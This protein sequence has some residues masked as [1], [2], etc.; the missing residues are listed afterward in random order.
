[1]KTPPNHLFPRLLL[2][3]AVLLSFN[4]TYG[5]YTEIR[6]RVI[7]SKAKDSSMYAVAYAN[8]RLKGTLA[9]T[10][11]DADGFFYLRTLERSD[12][13]IVSYIGYKDVRL[14]ISKGKIQDIKIDMGQKGIELREVTVKPKRTKHVID[15]AA[16]YVYHHVV[17]NKPKNKE[18]HIESYKLQEYNKLLIGVINPRAWFLKLRIL[19]PF[20]FALNNRDSTITGTDT[21]VSIPALMKEDLTDVYY[22]KN[23]KATRNI[24]RATQFT[25]IDNASIGDLLNYTFDKIN[26]YDDIFVIMQKSF[27]SPFAPGASIAT[28]DY[29]ILDTLRLNGRTSYKLNFVGKSKVDLA[30]KGYA[31]VDSATWAVKSI[32][33]RPNE[34]ANINYLKDYNISQNYTLVDGNTWMLQSEDIQTQ[35]TLFKKPKNQMGVLLKKHFSRKNI[36]LNPQ[37]DD[38]IFKGLEKDQVMDDARDKSRAY[39]DSSRF[40]PL[41]R[42][43]SRLI[44]IHDTIKRVPAYKAW[45]WTINLFTSANFKIGPIDV[46]RFY[47]FVSKNNVE[48]IRLRVGVQTNTSFSKKMHF[49]GYGAYGLKDKDFKYN[50][51]A[52]FV[53]P[54]KNDKWR[55]LEIAYQYDMNVLGQENILLTF[56][57]VL[58]LLSAGSLTRIMKIREWSVSLE[59]EWIRGFS[60]VMSVNN[61][62]YYD[63]PGVFDFKVQKPD[64]TPRSVPTFS[65]FE[66][67][68][69]SRFSNHDRYFKS[70]FYRYFIATKHPVFMLKAN[71]GLLDLDGKRMPYAK[72][73]LTYKH[74][75]SWTLGHTF[76]QAEAAK[77][78]G[79]AP[80]PTAYV[81]PGGFGWLW[82][83]G[84][85]YNMLREFEFVTD[86]YAAL[87]F[88]HHFEGYFF[89]KIPWVNRLQLREVL[90]ARMLWGSY[91]QKNYNLLKPGFDFHSPT[92]YPYLEAGFGFENIFKILT[93]YSIWRVSYRNEPGTKP[94]M[95]KL[96]FSVAF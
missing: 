18:D 13:L 61:R 3:F 10:T 35:A 67:G 49:S 37:V 23:P 29:F 11:T 55:Q 80:Y 24:V 75:I 15:T 94:W 43:E 89:N 22:R 93:V 70:G 79:P 4:Q 44:Y 2:F 41:S 8:I 68:I 82:N 48:G 7:D 73:K 96:G 28:Y 5:Q 64:G 60:S 39:W 83:G 84:T 58:T 85:D 21:S 6:G 53:L 33:F 17:D 12:T 86:Q 71:A 81:T 42:S 92:Q 62:T 65:T 25:G 52:H 78:F 9:G 27:V 45:Y 40:D 72:L 59:N 20:L 30:L 88:E 1:M 74:R 77:I 19:R 46:G 63:I 16:L 95:P 14:K 56:D 57:N 54:T 51:T 38:T 50:L 90:Y 87:Y 31:W 32:N 76:I 47:K 91:S 36:E 34:K 66:V 69:D 26:V